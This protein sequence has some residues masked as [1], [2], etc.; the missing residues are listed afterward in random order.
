MNKLLREHAA[1]RAYND[2]A[3]MC[4]G[5]RIFSLGLDSLEKRPKRSLNRRVRQ[6]PRKSLP[7]HEPMGARLLRRIR[8]QRLSIQSDAATAALQT[9]GDDE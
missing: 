9:L 1:W 4:A 7:G 6:K 3:E 8:S 5:S 2:A